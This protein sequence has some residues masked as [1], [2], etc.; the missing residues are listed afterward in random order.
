MNYNSIRQNIK[1]NKNVS[2]NMNELYKQMKKIIV[3]QSRY[4]YIYSRYIK[5]IMASV[6]IEHVF[7]NQ[8]PRQKNERK[9]KYINSVG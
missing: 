4:I 2:M 9:E 6:F 1:Q 3:K 7:S 8:W 5:I